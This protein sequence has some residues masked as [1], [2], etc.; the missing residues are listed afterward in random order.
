VILKHPATGKERERS[1]GEPR[2]TNNRM[3]LTAVI[4]GLRAL[5][6]GQRYRVQVVTD[7]EYVQRGMSEWLPGWIRKNW[8]T[9]GRTPVK[10]A[11]LWKALAELAAQHEITFMHTYGHAGHPENE[12]ADA[13]AVAAA[14]A[15][16]KG[17]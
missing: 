11:E 13:L 5:K 9:A 14:R 17:A 2:T 10:N 12:R 8:R 7:S 16:A 6:P 3:E 1:G 15:A 4:E